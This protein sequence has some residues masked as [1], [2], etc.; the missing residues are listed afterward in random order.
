MVAGG[1]DFRQLLLSALVAVEQIVH[2]TNS[3][4]HVRVYNFFEQLEPYIT[5]LAMNSVRIAF[6]SDATQTPRVVD[7]SQI[8]GLLNDVLVDAHLREQVANY[9][10]SELSQIGNYRGEPG[11]VIADNPSQI[12][13]K[14]N[15]SGTYEIPMPD[16]TNQSV[17]VRGYIKADRS[18]IEPTFTIT[19]VQV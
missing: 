7:L 14:P 5:L 19:C 10:R 3:S 17:T 9:I 12:V 8:G 18:W 4:D 6:S 11:S 1:R 16:G 15:L 13:V 2:E